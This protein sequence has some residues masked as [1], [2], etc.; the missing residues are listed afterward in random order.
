MNETGYREVEAAAIV[1]LTLN[2]IIERYKI[3]EDS[4]KAGKDKKN[5]RAMHHMKDLFTGKL[6]VPVRARISRDYINHFMFFDVLGVHEGFAKQK[7]HTRELQDYLFG[8]RKK[9][10]YAINLDGLRNCFLEE[11]EEL[12]EACL[13]L[14]GKIA[15]DDVC[16]PKADEK[17]KK[18]KRWMYTTE[19]LEYAPVV[20]DKD[21]VL[22]A[23]AE[24]LLKNI[25]NYWKK[26]STEDDEEDVNDRNEAIQ[27]Y[28]RDICVSLALYEIFLTEFYKEE[29]DQYWE[30]QEHL[31]EVGECFELLFGKNQ[32]LSEADKE[33]LNKRIEKIAE[34][35]E[36]YQLI[37]EFLL[38]LAHGHLRSCR[39]CGRT[40]LRERGP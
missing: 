12:W 40:C 1:Y 14:P 5:L 24:C 23:I 39:G 38:S 7:L 25:R 26:A 2:E 30:F 6:V 16:E 22:E 11:G 28:Y 17:G 20:L 10:N 21:Y 15:I 31:Q 36:Q 4:D 35:R 18:K 27:E 32:E 8:Y 33:A 3:R 37:L 34:D 19:T 9:C 13:T 29:E